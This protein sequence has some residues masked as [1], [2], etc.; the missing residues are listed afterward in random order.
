[1]RTTIVGLAIASL[2]AVA[3]AQSRSYQAGND[4]LTIFPKECHQ[5]AHIDRGF[6]F[7]AEYTD[8]KVVTKGCWVTNGSL[9]YVIYDDGDMGIVDMSSFTKDK[10]S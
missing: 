2:C 7:Y 6:R 5:K 10:D 1:M 8:G 3:V 4:R 9:V